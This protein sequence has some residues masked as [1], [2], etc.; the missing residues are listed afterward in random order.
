VSAVRLVQ[1][2]FQKE[3]YRN[4]V[5]VCLLTR[6]SN[7]LYSVILQAGFNIVCGEDKIKVPLKN[8]E[9]QLLAPSCLSVHPSALQQLGV[10]RTDFRQILYFGTFFEN[11]FKIIQ[12][13]L[14]SDQD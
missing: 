5:A 13:S 1:I 8:R 11:L 14:K 10:H 2:T 9:K 6:I 3:T 4:I 12:V 7:V